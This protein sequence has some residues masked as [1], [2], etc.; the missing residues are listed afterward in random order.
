MRPDGQGLGALALQ[1]EA[2]AKPVVAAL[3]GNALGAGLELALAAHGR[4]ALAEARL[5]L[6]EVGLGLPPVAGAT[7]RLPRL[8][9]AEAA[10]KVLLEGRPLSAVEALTIGLVDHVVEG[11]LIDRAM[12]FAQEL[13][14]RPRVAALAR[15]EGLRDGRGYQAA[16]ARARAATAGGRLPAP[17]RIVDCVEAAQLL[18]GEAGLGYERAAFEELA[19]TPEMQGLFHAFLAERAAQRLPAALQGRPLPA[20]EVLAIW[21]TGG[22]AADLAQAAL[23]AGLR[24]VLAAP[25]R[26]ALGAAL[27]RVAARQEALVAAGRLSPAARDADWSRLAGQLGADGLAAAMAGA[28]AAAGLVL[29][30]PGAAAEALPPQA[31]VAALADPQAALAFFPPAEAG[32]LAE[33]LAADPS[34]AALPALVALGRRLGLR[35]GFSGAGGPPALRLR[36]ALSRLASALV[37]GGLDRATVAGALAG[38]GIGAAAAAARRPA[39]PPEAAD[40]VPAALAALAC[41][42]LRML[43]E[44][45]VARAAEIDAAATLS[46]LFPRWQ[47]GPLHWAA[48]RGPM[49][50]RADLLHRAAT[51]PGLFT[52]P[53]LLDRLVAGTARL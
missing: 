23:A 25:D 4:V 12:A 18:P 13:A 11:G 48:Q 42:G 29:V 24:V 43:D 35:L 5:G 17:A 51:A 15:R 10:L 27:E 2:M 50:L 36:A 22:P 39:P 47:G 9:G 49:V 45:V 37:A 28:P 40:V 38:F 1:I 30:A 44:G 52:P 21:G 41:E 14:G 26:A 20:L 53:P 7:Q 6:P 31:P 16:V 3:Q 32:G 34:D 8:V 33:I 19:A 46:G